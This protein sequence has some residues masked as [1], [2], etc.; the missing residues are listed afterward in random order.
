MTDVELLRLHYAFNLFSHNAPPP[1][2]RTA[3]MRR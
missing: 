1:C 3:T 2:N